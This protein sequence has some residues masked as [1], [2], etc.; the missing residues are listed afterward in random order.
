MSGARPSTDTPRVVLVGLRG[1]G[2]SSVGAALALALD[3]PF[4]DS[5]AELLRRTGQSAAEWIEG[6]GEAE[7]RRQERAVVLDLADR[8]GVLALGGGAPTDPDSRAS[9]ASWRAVLLDAPDAVLAARAETDPDTRRPP[10]SPRSRSQELRDQR[11]TRTSAYCALDPLQ[12]D[13]ATL[14]PEQ[15]VQ[16]ILLW[17]GH[18]SSV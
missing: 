7:F 9:L 16:R 13:T 15:V 17:L 11:T 1:A 3:C 12:I 6:S 8:N 2:K 5:D 14:T 18:G 4:H 10:L